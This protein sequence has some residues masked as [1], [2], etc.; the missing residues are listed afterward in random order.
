MNFL[1]THQQ[2][3][4]KVTVN[5]TV[6]QINVTPVKIEEPPKVQAVQKNPEKIDFLS[7]G[8]ANKN[9]PTFADLAKSTTSS[10]FSFA[11]A[12]DA[13]P[14]LF[15]GFN[16]Q[17]STPLINTKIQ[18]KLF[19]GQGAID[20]AKEEEEEGNANPEEFEPQV[21][22]KPLVA[23]KEVEVKTGEE[24][25]E[26]LFK[27]RCKLYR[28]ATE[29]KEWK[30]KG[31]G[32]IKILKHKQ[33]SAYRVLMRRDQVLKLCS[34]HRILPEIKLEIANEKQVRWSTNDYSENEAKY[35]ILLAKFRHEDEAKRFVNEFEKAQKLYSSTSPIKPSAQSKTTANGNSKA[36]SATP[37]KTLTTSVSQINI[38]KG[39]PSLSES[40]KVEKGTWSCTGCL[41]SL[42]Y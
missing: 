35:E 6:K 36:E 15:G 25:E 22:F 42:K 34:N 8:I 3:Q 5:E 26:V 13:K 10:P 14:M 17:Q 18:P 20:T 9:M 33:T 7:L 41:V 11:P 19:S 27:E 28:F 21:D 2:Q 32:E 39:K 40:F 24:D 23:L 38:T 16:Q 1:K 4:S 12:A 31:V 29:T 30:E 37:L